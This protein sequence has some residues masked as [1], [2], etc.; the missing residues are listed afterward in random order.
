MVKSVRQIAFLTGVV[1]FTQGA[2][3]IAGIALPLYLRSL[4]W[5][6]SHIT[7]IGSFVAF[8]WVLKILYGLV[9]D[10]YPVFGYRRKSY[11]LL[12]AIISAMGWFLLSFLPAK[13]IWIAAFL[14][15]ANLGFAATDVVTDGLVVEYSTAQA[16]PIFQS[17]AW[18]A[19]SLGAF[20]SG[21]IGGWLAGHW[22]YGHVF[23]LTILLPCLVAMTALMIDEEKQN[24]KIFNSAIVPIKRCFKLLLSS[25]LRWLMGLLSIISVSASFGVPLFFYMKEDL[26]F[27]E[28][29][30]G[31][32]TSLGWGGAIIGS[33]IYLKWLKN[34]NPKKVLSWAIAMSCL[35][36]MSAVFIRG[37]ISAII[38]ITVGGVL[39]CLTIVPM[40]A[41]AANL[42][43]KTGVEGTLFAILMSWYN[44]GQIFFGFIGGKVHAI[45]GLY[46]LII[47]SGLLV[48]SGF[49]CVQNLV[50]GESKDEFK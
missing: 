10:T 28:E 4:G 42:T 30:M 6:I 50:F 22:S 25:N 1:Y 41:A 33:L 14:F 26:R 20:M 49:I 2:L 23:R 36:I 19:R 27:G 45:I 24:K 15:I 44:L 9:S 29:F 12:C 34:I 40:M 47:A 48:L 46:P 7:A 13:T 32:L 43:H 39:G 35:N 21:A 17:I 16:S 31:I 8:P 18:G 38:V 37:S 5:S 11:L 3:G